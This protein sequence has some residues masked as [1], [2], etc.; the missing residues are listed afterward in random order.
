MRILTPGQTIVGMHAFRHTLLTY[1]FNR[2]IARI[3]LITGHA[4]GAS[5]VVAGYQAELLLEKKQA[6][7]ERV[8]FDLAP[9]KWSPEASPGAASR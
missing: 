6:I 5:K 7:L 8:Q 2:D 1:G 9:P 4:T 3:E